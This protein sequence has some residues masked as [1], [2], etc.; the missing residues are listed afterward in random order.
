VS[1][2]PVEPKYVEVSMAKKHYVE[3]GNAGEPSAVESHQT[4]D[5]IAPFKA[6]CL[7]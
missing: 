5:G 6:E 2:A 3:R 4:S 7:R 1:H